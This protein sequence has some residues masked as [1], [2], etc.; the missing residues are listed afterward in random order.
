MIPSHLKVEFDAGQTGDVAALALEAL[1]IR[2]SICRRID[3]LGL[4]LDVIK[5]AD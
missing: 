5:K 3:L 4:L 2:Q 1:R